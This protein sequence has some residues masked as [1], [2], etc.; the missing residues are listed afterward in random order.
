MRWEGGGF[1]VDDI[2]EVWGVYNGLVTYETVL[3]GER[4]IPDITA[5]EVELLEKGE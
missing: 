2:I 5:V 4:T 3:G 1:L